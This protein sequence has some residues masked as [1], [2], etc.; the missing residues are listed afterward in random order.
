MSL[1]QPV[2][3]KSHQS[4]TSTIFSSISIAVNQK[5]ISNIT[6]QNDSKNYFENTFYNICQKELSLGHDWSKDDLD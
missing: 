5:Y 6:Q 2:F 3:L 4:N 1:E